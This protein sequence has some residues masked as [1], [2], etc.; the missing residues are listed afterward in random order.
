MTP[1]QIRLAWRAGLLLL[2]VGLGVL[3]WALFFRPGQLK[4]DA[5]AARTETTVAQG[6]VAKAA[7]AR[8]VTERQNDVIRE[9]ERTTITNERTIRAAPGASDPVPDAVDRALRAALCMRRAYHSS[10]ACHQLPDADPA[11]LAGADTGGGV[12]D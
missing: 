9:I 2:V 11:Y 3:I 12:P 8:A 5:A 6:E 7:D 1:A 4:A 10:P